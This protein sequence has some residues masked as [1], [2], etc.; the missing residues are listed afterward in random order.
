ML[1]NQNIGLYNIVR[2]NILSDCY[3]WVADIGSS[4]ESAICMFRKPMKNR[5]H[6]QSVMA[7]QLLVQAVAELVGISANLVQLIERKNNAPFIKFPGSSCHINASLSHSGKYVA[8]VVSR[9]ALVGLDIEV[10]KIRNNFSEIAELA[11][12]SGEYN[13]L[14]KQ[15]ASDRA[16]TFYKLWTRREA[17]FK[18]QT[19][20][21]SVTNNIPDVLSDSCYE[22]FTEL[23]KDRRLMISVCAFSQVNR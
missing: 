17:I 8:C 23:Q 14:T 7:R 6:W 22:W 21:P 19:N 18:L 16:E 3:L 20:M 5:R 15:L 12:A 9:S 2:R 1:N 13:W 10:L 11:F 4:E